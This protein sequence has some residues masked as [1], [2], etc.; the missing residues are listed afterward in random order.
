MIS[1]I[2]TVENNEITQ[3]RMTNER[4]CVIT[5]CKDER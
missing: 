5:S 1:D 3:L 4:G 2:A